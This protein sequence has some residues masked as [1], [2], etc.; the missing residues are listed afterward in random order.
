MAE[1]RELHLGIPRPSGSESVLDRLQAAYE[2]ELA[3]DA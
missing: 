3:A 2:A 1:L